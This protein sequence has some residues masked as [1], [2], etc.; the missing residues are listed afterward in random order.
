MKQ[1]ITSVL[2]VL[3]IIHAV[4]SQQFTSGETER[5]FGQE[6]K[7]EYEAQFVGYIGAGVPVYS[8]ALCFVPEW[9]ID[10]IHPRAEDSDTFCV[11]RII[12]QSPLRFKIAYNPKG[13]HTDTIEKFDKFGWVDK[14]NIGYAARSGHK[15]RLYEN[16]DETSDY[17]EFDKDYVDQERWTIAGDIDSGYFVLLDIRDDGF[18]KV[19]FYSFGKLY[20]GWI[21]NK[22][23]NNAYEIE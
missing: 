7:Q 17:I 3:F 13:T 11:F 23:Y 16:P 18:R 15:L 22:P 10:T 21:I 12:E 2:S 5:A 9:P 6:Q 14:K 8:K 1:V 19:M 4:L 20:T